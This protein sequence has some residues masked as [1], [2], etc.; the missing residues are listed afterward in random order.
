[1]NRLK[2]AHSY[3]RKTARAGQSL[4]EFGMVMPLLVLILLG[5]ASFGIGT[6]EAHMASDAIQLTSLHKVDVAKIPGA[7]GGGTLLGYVTSGGT[8][9]TLSAGGLID[10]ITTQDIDNYT[11]MAIGSKSFTPLASFVPG[12]TIK[13]AEAI[14]KGLTDAAN[15]GGA[16]VRPAGTPWVPGGTPVKPPWP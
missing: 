16:T 11:T 4:M 15:T 14:N 12:F 6:Y 2:Q 8:S 9:G 10:S 13:T 7:A 5:G 1:M 3:F